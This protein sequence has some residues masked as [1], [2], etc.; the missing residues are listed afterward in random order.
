MLTNASDLSPSFARGQLLLLRHAA[1]GESLALLLNKPT[2]LSLVHAARLLTLFCI[3]TGGV[4]FA[5]SVY[6]RK[7]RLLKVSQPGFLCA[8]IVGSTLSLSAVFPASRDHLTLEPTA[9]TADGDVTFPQLDIACNM[10]V[11]RQQSR[12]RRRNRRRGP[13]G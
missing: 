2:P 11:W 8:I 9:S 1:E 4:F 5:W 10:Q 3:A 13:S 12:N 7:S 6:H